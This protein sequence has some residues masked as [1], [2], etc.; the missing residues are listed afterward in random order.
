MKLAVV[1]ADVLRDGVGIR[2][3]E[4]EGADV[5]SA[6]GRRIEWQQRAVSRADARKPVEKR[7]RH[8]V[9]ADERAVVGRHF[10]DE[11]EDA[12]VGEDAKHLAEHEL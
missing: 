3:D 2:D 5:E 1:R 7:R 4:V 9:D 8:L 6:N 11:R 10:V 12:R